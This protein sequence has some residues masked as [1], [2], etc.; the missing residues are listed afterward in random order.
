MGVHF[1]FSFTF[2]LQAF[3]PFLLRIKLILYIY[4]Y[5]CKGI[6]FVKRNIFSEFFLLSSLWWPKNANHVTFIEAYLM[7]TENHVL[8]KKCTFFLRR[9]INIVN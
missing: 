8:V 7:C 1:C 4:I 3:A 9:G 5:I 6:F 2:F